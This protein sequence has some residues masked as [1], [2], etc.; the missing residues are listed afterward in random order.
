[1]T[2]T[3]LSQRVFENLIRSFLYGVVQL[4]AA[5]AK[6]DQALASA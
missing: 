1:M 6:A 5:L 4:D 2:S 3:T